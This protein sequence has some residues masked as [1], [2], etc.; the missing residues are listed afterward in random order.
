MGF[1]WINDEHKIRIALSQ[2]AYS[3]IQDDMLIFSVDKQTNFINTIITNFRD[4]AIA[5]LSIFLEKKR[6]QY[7][8]ILLNSNLKNSDKQI[9]INHL[10]ENDKQSALSRISRY[11]S[12]KAVTKLYHINKDKIDYLTED[13]VEQDHFNEKPGLYLKCII[14]EYCELS[15]IER[16]RIIKR[17]EYSTI[18]IAIQ[19]GRQLQIKTTVNGKPQTYLVHPYAIF[20]DAQN[21]QEYLAC[22]SHMRSVSPKEKQIASFSIARLNNLTLLKKKSFISNSDR[23]AIKSEI[24]KKS[25]AFLLGETKEIRVRLTSAGRKLYLSKINSRPAKDEKLSSDDIYVFLCSEFQA[26]VYFFPFGSDAE[27]LSPETLRKKMIEKY[28]NALETY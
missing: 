22:F 6:E 27:I 11:K 25:V 7:E 10:I 26:Y 23:K 5:T 24:E 28:Q 9:A 19:T 2:K 8:E 1:S 14:E 18:A 21:T 4:D 20:P 15:L 13:C 16:E 17:N 12:D 3:T